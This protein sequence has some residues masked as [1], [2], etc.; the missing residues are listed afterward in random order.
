MVRLA[1]ERRGSA[2]A[3]MLGCSRSDTDGN[4]RSDGDER[5]HQRQEQE[6]SHHPRVGAIAQPVASVPAGHGFVAGKCVVAGAWM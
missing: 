4:R 5:G 2:V 1:D 6:T 3:A